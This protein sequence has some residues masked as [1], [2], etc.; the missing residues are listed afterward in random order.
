MKMITGTDYRYVV[1]HTAITP[2]RPVISIFV[3]GE[4][5]GLMWLLK[6]KKPFYATQNSV[7]N[8]HSNE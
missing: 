6:F 3:I 1:P 7:I 5:I 4:Q 8:C 2:S